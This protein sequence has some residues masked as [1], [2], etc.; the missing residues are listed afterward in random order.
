MNHQPQ[1]PQRATPASRSLSSAY[2]GFFLALGGVGV[3]LAG[4]L[5]SLVMLFFGPLIMCGVTLFTVPIGP[6]AAVMGWLGRKEHPK[7]ALAAVLLGLALPLVALA[8]TWAFG[9]I[10][11]KATA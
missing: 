6:A 1:P 3:V 9:T 7:V 4:L 11:Y 2:L 10:L 5:M 8:L